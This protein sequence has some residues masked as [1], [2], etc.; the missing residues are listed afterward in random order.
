MTKPC[1]TH[2]DIRCAHGGV[3]RGRL[4]WEGKTGRPEP[5][6]QVREC[7]WPDRAWECVRRDKMEQTNNPD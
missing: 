5:L 7:K 2:P 6:A 1:D 4:Y 3:C